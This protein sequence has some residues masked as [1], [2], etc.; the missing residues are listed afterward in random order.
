MRMATLRDACVVEKVS[1]R[2]IA[3]CNH[4]DECLR[5]GHRRNDDPVRSLQ[6]LAAWRVRGDLGRRGSAGW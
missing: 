4:A 6:R 2:G 3:L 1:F 5:S